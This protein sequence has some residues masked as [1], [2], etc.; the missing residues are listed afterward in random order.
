MYKSKSVKSEIPSPLAS[1]IVPAASC[2]ATA[3]LISSSVSVWASTVTSFINFFTWFVS[4]SLKLIS[5]I[6]LLPDSDIPFDGSVIVVVWSPTVT[7]SVPTLPIESST[8][9]TC[10]SSSEFKPVIKVPFRATSIS[11]ILIFILPFLFL[12]IVPDSKVKLPLLNNIINSGFWERLSKFF[13]TKVLSLLKV[14]IELSKKDIVALLFD[15][16]TISLP[17]K[18]WSNTFRFIFFPLSFLKALPSKDSIKPT[19]FSSA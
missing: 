19:N 15:S 6:S 18:I 1:G 3:R 8:R 9:E 12:A 2:F 5:S 7:L 14:K 11:E 4:S 17:T 10:C 16:I 13:T